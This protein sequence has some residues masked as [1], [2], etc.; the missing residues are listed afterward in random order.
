MEGEGKDGTV[1]IESRFCVFC[2]N[3]PNA[4]TR[5]HVVPHWLLEMTGDPKRVVT[6]GQDFAKSKKPIRYSWSSYVAPACD[7]C[8][9]KF[10]E[11]EG[12]IKT[13]IEALQR[14]EALSVADYVELLDW[15]DKV[16]VGVWLLRHMVENHPRPIVPN[17][18]ISTRIAQ[19]DRMVALYFFD[20]GNKGINLFG[21]DSLI[22]NEMPSCFG[23]RINDMLLIN[24]SS[25]FMCSAG[26][27]FPHPSKMKL[28]IGGDLS[29]QT[30]FTD[31]RNP[32]ETKHPL[33]KL[34]LF[35][36]VVWL[37]QP[38][39]MPTTN[40][41]F[42]GGFLGHVN[43]LDSRLAGLKLEGSD[44]EGVLFRQFDDRV[45]IHRSLSDVVE[46]DEVSGNASGR[47]RDIAASVYDAQKHIANSVTYE[48]HLPASQRRFEKAYR[49]MT[50]KHTEELARMYRSG[51]GG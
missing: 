19:K 16:R 6:F 42:R 32:N 34:R 36:P 24:A 22:F 5:E 31:F 51:R 47:L 27:G 2:G 13:K 21:A 26:C 17:F 33:T 43:L 3:T 49:K 23:L 1:L 20:R 9:S 7:A 18:H 46:F 45:E 4:K 30:V 8:N 29:G 40:P 12:R 39:A 15:L 25:D 48:W 28:R 44:R 11:L 37:Y 14:L 38:I 10:S 35:K 50:I 41:V